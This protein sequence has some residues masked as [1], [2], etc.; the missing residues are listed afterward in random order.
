MPLNAVLLLV[1]ILSCL[2]YGILLGPD[3]TRNFLANNR[4]WLPLGYL[5][6]LGYITVVKNHIEGRVIGSKEY[7][8]SLGA[9]LL[10]GMMLIVI[11]VAI[12]SLLAKIW[13]GLTWCDNALREWRESLKEQ[14]TLRVPT[15][16][17]EG[18][19]FKF[20]FSSSSAT[21]FFISSPGHPPPEL[22]QPVQSHPIAGA[23][24]LTSGFT[25]KFSSSFFSSFFFPNKFL[26]KFIFLIFTNYI[27]DIMHYHDISVPISSLQSQHHQLLPLA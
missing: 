14:Q 4:P 21:A 13:E 19:F 27:S 18:A 9:V 25:S 16:E 5:A 22:G 15:K 10:L 1:F 26:K 2:I 17:P 7:L 3:R 6:V 12:G 11:G 8:S 24:S 23:S 20:Y